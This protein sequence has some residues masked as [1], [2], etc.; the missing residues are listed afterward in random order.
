MTSQPG[1]SAIFFM[2]LVACLWVSDV[3]MANTATSGVSDARFEALR[4]K[5]VTAM[6]DIKV[7]GVALGVIYGDKEYVAGLGVTNVNNPQS[8]DGDTLFPIGSITKIFT[9]TAMMKLVES[10]KAGLDA[11]GTSVLP[12]P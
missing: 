9:A 6:Q 10:G 5:A 7:P 12:E 3:A 2:S 1:L 4:G 11:P 8:V